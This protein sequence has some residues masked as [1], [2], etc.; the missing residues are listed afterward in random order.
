MNLVSSE[1]A[2]QLFTAEEMAA[3]REQEKATAA[4]QRRIL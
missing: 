2:M 4:L 1:G 3:V